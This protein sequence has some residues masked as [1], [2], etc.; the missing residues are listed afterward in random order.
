MASGAGS[1][2]R[3]GKNFLT[4]KFNEKQPF[5]IRS[6]V[7]EVENV[8]F[9]SLSWER[10]YK[11]GEGLIFNC[12][13]KEILIVR[14]QVLVLP[15]APQASQKSFLGTITPEPLHRLG[16]AA[17][18][19]SRNV[20]NILSSNSHTTFKKNVYS[21]GSSYIKNKISGYARTGY[22]LLKSGARKVASFFG[23]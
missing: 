11:Q 19:L 3:I 4:A 1:V 16:Q 2:R 12:T 5:T 6:E 17:T 18:R 8:F 9:E 10:D 20:D 21:A 7:D 15:R 22:G 13:L 23:F 14:S